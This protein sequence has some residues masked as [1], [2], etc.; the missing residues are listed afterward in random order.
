MIDVGFY[1]K[2]FILYLVKD[3]NW[4]I[5]IRKE[6]IQ[7]NDIIDKINKACAEVLFFK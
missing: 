1:S 5:P 7:E 6:Y 4:N 3:Y 2:K